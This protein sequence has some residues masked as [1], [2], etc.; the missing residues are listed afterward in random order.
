MDAYLRDPN[1][2]LAANNSTDWL[3]YDDAFEYG[4]VDLH[5]SSGCLIGNY[6]L[7]LFLYDD[8]GQYEDLYTNQTLYLYPPYVHELNVMVGGG[9]G[10]T[11]PPPGTHI[12]VNGTEAR[13]E[14]LPD[15]GWMLESG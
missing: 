13:V 14:A 3:I 15:L 7:E 5:V 4:V 10:A 8:Y 6:T 9:L 2:T 12:Y 11:D 1:G